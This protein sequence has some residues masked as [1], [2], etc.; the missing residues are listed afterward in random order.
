MKTILWSKQKMFCSCLMIISIV[1]Y[2]AG[3]GMAYHYKSNQNIESDGQI[4]NIED[5]Y[6]RDCIMDYAY[7]KNKRDEKSKYKTFCQYEQDYIKEV[8]SAPVIICAVATGNIKQKTTS[9]GQEVLV[10]KV[11]KGASELEGEKIMVYT[12]DGFVKAKRGWNYMGIK[13]PMKKNQAYVI[14][15]NEKENNVWTL[16]EGT[17]NYLCIEKDQKRTVN[18]SKQT[19]MEEYRDV[20]FFVTSERLMEQMLTI[21]HKILEEIKSGCKTED[22]PQI[23]N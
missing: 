17:F 16:A 12:A 21:K 20:E 13:N 2:F 3:I 6:A 15:M 23:T 22:M 19:K 18:W 8:L 10:E 5:L 7:G 1:I 11:Y 4:K 14:F 9:F